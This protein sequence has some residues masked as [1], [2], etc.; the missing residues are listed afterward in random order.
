M[1]DPGGGVQLNAD[2]ISKGDK[3][4]LQAAYEQGALGYIW[5]DNL[6]S[7]YGAVNG[8]RYYG[9]GYT[10]ADTSTG[11]NTNLYD[12]I[13]TL[14]GSCE[15][16]TGWAVTAAYKHYWIPTLASAIY[17]SYAQI[18]YSNN[19]IAGYGGAVGVSNLKTARIGTNLVWT[20]VKGFDIGAEFMYVKVSQTRPVGLASDATIIAKGV[21]AWQGSE[22]QYE[23]R[24]RVQRAF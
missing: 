5:G 10:P 7:S 20:P 2:V 4:W 17:G 19:A 9:S 15:R 24:V 18:N 8:N 13:F 6:S 23:G 22:N 14:S 12:S 21:P 3:L 1:G 11:W 16:Q